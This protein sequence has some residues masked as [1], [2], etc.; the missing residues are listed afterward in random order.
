MRCADQVAFFIWARWWRGRWPDRRSPPCGKANGRKSLPTGRFGCRS[1][2]VTSKHFNMSSKAWG[3]GRTCFRRHDDTDGFNGKPRSRSQPSR[4]CMT[5]RRGSNPRSRG[6]SHVDA[7]ER[8]E[9]RAFLDRLLALRQPVGS[10]PRQNVS[11]LQD[12]RR[13]RAYRRL[14]R[15]RG[16]ALDRVVAVCHAAITG[17]S[18]THGDDGAGAVEV[19]HRRSWRRR[20]RQGRGGGRSDQVVD[21][22]H[23]AIFRE[24]LITYM[25]EDLRKYNCHAHTSVVHREEFQNGWRS[26]HQYCRE[27]A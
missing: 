10:D 1:R 17:W 11:A 15:Q 14:C 22:T 16:K 25:M 12:H 21:D 3:P 7:L 27:P 23:N 6:G 2:G 24:R 19:D 26:C 9:D 18:C 8:A 5:P 13:D 4:P 20:R